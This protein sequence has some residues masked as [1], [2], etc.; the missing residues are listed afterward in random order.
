M[1]LTDILQGEKYILRLSL[2]PEPEMSTSPLMMVDRE[3]TGYVQRPLAV[4]EQIVKNDDLTY[5]WLLSELPLACNPI[6]G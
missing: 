5:I 1:L 2:H 4:R 6:Q 3:I